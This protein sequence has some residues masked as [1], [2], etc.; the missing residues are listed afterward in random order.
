MDFLEGHGPRPYKS[1]AWPIG[2]ASPGNKSK[3]PVLHGIQRAVVHSIRM[4]E[5]HDGQEIR[6]CFV[7]IDA[8]LSVPR[9]ESFREEELFR[10]SRRDRGEFRICEKLARVGPLM[11]CCIQQAQARNKFPLLPV[12]NGPIYS[13][14]Q[15]EVS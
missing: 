2:Q 13:D 1:L 3:F 4:S 14:I 12:R 8:R 6:T 5:A 10:Q 11:K 7:R 9:G 15:F